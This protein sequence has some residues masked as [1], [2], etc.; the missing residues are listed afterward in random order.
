M[1]NI[2]CSDVFSKNIWTILLSSSYV[3]AGLR[4][5]SHHSGSDLES[6]FVCLLP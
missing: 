1:R 3:L 5:I 6:T 4:E 2:D